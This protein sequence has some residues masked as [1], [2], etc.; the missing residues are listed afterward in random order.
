M[1]QIS[2]YWE[3]ADETVRYLADR[4]SKSLRL[5]VT[6]LDEFSLVDDAVI[7]SLRGMGFDVDVFVLGSLAAAG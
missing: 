4:L 6:L 5:G 1:R 7:A 2:P 3:L